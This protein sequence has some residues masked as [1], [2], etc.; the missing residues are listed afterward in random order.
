M[1]IT[2]L[3]L[4]TNYEIFMG[5]TNGLNNTVLVWKLKNCERWQ[6]KI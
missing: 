6:N 5:K 3:K 4:L 2:W 1:K